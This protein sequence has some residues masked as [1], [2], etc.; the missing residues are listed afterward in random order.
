MINFEYKISKI[1]QLQKSN[2]VFMKK[3]ILFFVLLF[4]SAVTVT[5]AINVPVGKNSP[6]IGNG[7]QRVPMRIPFTIDLSTTDLYLNFTNTVDIATIVITDNN[8]AIV[9]QESI[10]TN[11]TTEIYIP[12]N[13]FEIGDYTIT[14]SYG[15]ITLAGTFRI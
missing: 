3:P 1:N 6:T 13:E 9:Q 10:D 14:I 12:I 4:L 11:V 8:G 5:N 2:I 7:R 15:S